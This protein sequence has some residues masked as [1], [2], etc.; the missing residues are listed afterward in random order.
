MIKALRMAFATLLL[1]TVVPNV[2]QADIILSYTGQLFTKTEGAGAF[3]KNV[4]RITAIV[5][6]EKS[7][8]LN[9]KAFSLSTTM[10]G[11]VG[12]T[13]HW[14]SKS[15]DSLIEYTNLF[16]KWSG[17]LPTE[18][19]LLAVGKVAGGDGQEQIDTS[20]DEE[21]GD[22]AIL[23]LLGEAP[24]FGGTKIIG[25]WQVVPEPSSIALFAAGSLLGFVVLRRRRSR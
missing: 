11:G 4:D 21:F 20:H 1:A 14:D 15:P 16:P 5:T 17:S 25:T 9:A 13:L 3:V 6:F 18:W 2:S 10:G 19:N 24:S 23:D 8:D 7:G 12:F 22:N